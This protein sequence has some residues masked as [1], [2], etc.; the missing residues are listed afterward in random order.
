MNPKDT[1]FKIKIIL[2]YLIPALAGFG[3][4]G[5]LFINV[6]PLINVEENK[7]DEIFVKVISTGST[8]SSLYECELL[9]MVFIQ[10]PTRQNYNNYE[11]ALEK[12]YA[13]I[14]SLG[15]ITN[16]PSQQSILQ[17]LQKLLDKKNGNML[18]IVRE[19]NRENEEKIIRRSL[20]EL[21][22]SIDSIPTKVIIHEKIRYDTLHPVP[23]KKRNVL[24][25]IKEVFFPSKPDTTVRTKIVR[26]FAKD[27]IQSLTNTY[28]T[29]FNTV[30]KVLEDVQI[31]KM[32]NKQTINKKL[33]TLLA[34][35]RII[36]AEI[37]SL[38]N[39]L[40]IEAFSTTTA[41][42]TEKQ[43]LL[44]KFGLLILT[45]GILAIL[46]IILFIFFV[47]NDLRKR[48]IHRKELEIARNHAEELMKSR[49]KLLLSI[50]HDIKAPLSSI[51]GYIELMDLSELDKNNHEYINSMKHSVEHVMELLNNLLEYSRLEA[52]KTTLSPEVFPLSALFE[53]TVSSFYPI[54]KRKNLDLKL[55]NQIPQDL[56]VEIDKI[57]LRQ[58][59]TNLLSNSLK[60]TDKGSVSIHVFF[61]DN[62]NEE[63]WLHF[64]ISDTGCGI[65]P[66]KREFI[67]E[68]F[69]QINKPEDQ[70]KKG[71]GF[72]LFIVK[73]IVELFNGNIAVKENEP[74][75]SVFSVQLPITIADSSMLVT[76]EDPLLHS[77]ENIN[78]L[79]VDDD[80]SQLKLMEKILLKLGF[81]AKSVS[82]IE[83]A[84]KLLEE[85]YFDILI[86]DI[87]LKNA[88][89]F[90]L[91]E[92]LKTSDNEHLRGLPVIAVSANEEYNKEYF[93][94]K[95]FSSFIK[96]PFSFQ[97]LKE[98]LIRIADKIAK[99][100]VITPFPVPISQG[101]T[102]SFNETEK[103]E[104]S[105]NIAY[106]L[107]S[108][109]LMMN[110]D[111]ESVKQVL[112]LFISSVEESVHLM[113]FYLETRNYYEIKQLAHK[114]LP[115]FR[116]LKIAGLINIL[117]F[118]D[119]YCIS[120]TDNMIFK[121]KVSNFTQQSEYV[122]EELKK[123]IDSI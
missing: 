48:K 100:D 41:I 122:I 63:K 35:D 23:V 115:M 96:K 47:F 25:R 59:L 16:Q 8:L 110:N 118:I 69:S 123:N 33:Q 44:K 103:D 105:F 22:L 28:D 121:G 21:K 45:M 97:Q 106:S 1:S 117:S 89:G 94:E 54:A 17:K 56:Y 4:A 32:R 10:E 27:T 74:E 37:N 49:E 120:E 42:I 111:T 57:R 83:E 39:E 112:T 20:S 82:N 14:D 119:S 2:G 43:A 67:F 88:T 73:R 55:S 80:I 13:Q 85:K 15:K 3:I 40:Q 71:S 79:V 84:V 77:I 18:A 60:F 102:I 11:A 26:T 76:H 24:G 65:P 29:V 68:E 98:E 9:S 101:E 19:I 86:T 6:I 50:S 90:E 91:L 93:M 58:I 7:K 113:K 52:Q 108:L 107:E 30:E 61:D 81:S 64:S 5:Y 51:A 66:E 34:T 116:Q 31:E 104:K 38:L 36:N 92:T 95:G 70:N 78:I 12:V 62:Y 87:Q 72:G 53:E 109:Y 99:E 46:T 114:M 75:G